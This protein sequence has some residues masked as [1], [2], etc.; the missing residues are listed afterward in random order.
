MTNELKTFHVS[1]VISASTGVLVSVNGMRGIYSILGYMAGQELFTHELPEVSRQAEKQL[2]KDFPFLSD[3][4][5]PKFNTQEDV[6]AFVAEMVEKHGEYLPVF[7]LKDV[8]IPTLSEAIAL[9][10][11]HLK[12]ADRD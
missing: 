7:P 9:A 11:E 12:E 1:D 5:L 6:A 2:T 8:F 3:L 10:K 4:E